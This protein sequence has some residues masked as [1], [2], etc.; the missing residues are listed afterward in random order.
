VPEVHFFTSRVSRYGG[1]YRID[2]RE[3]GRYIIFMEHGLYHDAPAGG[4]PGGVP[5]HLLQ[6][7][8]GSP[9]G[10][11]RTVEKEGETAEEPPSLVCKTCGT[12][13]TRQEYGIEVNSAHRHT[14]MKD[15]KSVV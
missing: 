12:V 5:L 2:N 11:V 13:I 14:F 15:R 10:D 7:L 6:K 8:D 4:L 3:N 9:D 1:G